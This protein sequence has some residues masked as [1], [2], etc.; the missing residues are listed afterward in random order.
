MS[1]KAFSSAVYFFEDTFGAVAGVEDAGCQRR[2][3]SLCC[4]FRE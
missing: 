4:D 1:C 3:A 2:V